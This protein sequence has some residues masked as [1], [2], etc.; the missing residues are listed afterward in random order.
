MRVDRAESHWRRA[1]QADFDDNRG[2]SNHHERH[3]QRIPP[4][5]ALPWIL[6]EDWPQWQAIDRGVP[7]YE[8]WV[9]LFDKNLRLAESYGWPYERIPVRPAQ[10][11]A[12]CKANKRSPMKFDR[13]L[14]A[15]AILREAPEKLAAPAAGLSEPGEIAKTVAAKIEPAPADNVANAAQGDSIASDVAS[16]SLPTNYFIEGEINVPAP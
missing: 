9:E 2:Q 15:L 16:S 11:E 10:F 7:S 14:F 5:L 3:V 12:W 8:K 1:N 6:E 13:S 4:K